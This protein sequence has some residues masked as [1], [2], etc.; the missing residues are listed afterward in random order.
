MSNNYSA[1]KFGAALGIGAL[2]VMVALEET[3]EALSQEEID[4]NMEV[5]QKVSS[6]LLK[7]VDNL[8]AKDSS[9]ENRLVTYDH[10]L[11]SQAKIY[12]HK[13]DKDPDNKEAQIASRFVLNIYEMAE[14]EAE[15]GTKAQVAKLDSVLTAFADGSAKKEIETNGLKVTGHDHVDAK[16]DTALVLDKF[17]KVG[18][19]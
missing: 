2:A 8:T 11:N 7:N 17:Q 3:P 12:Q 9:A 18:G 19:R 14:K 10:L 5:C 15:N 1:A 13:L 16:G 6:A 4:Q